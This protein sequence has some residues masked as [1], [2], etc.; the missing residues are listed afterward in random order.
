MGAKQQMKFNA[1]EIKIIVKQSEFYTKRDSIITYD[2][3]A[4]IDKTTKEIVPCTTAI[5][6]L[7]IH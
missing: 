3:R 4:V 1:G 2:F 7:N 5:R 6:K